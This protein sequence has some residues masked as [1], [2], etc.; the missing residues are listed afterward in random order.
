MFGAVTFA[1]PLQG[2]DMQLWVLIILHIDAKKRVKSR[3][4]LARAAAH[5]GV[6][7]RTVHPKSFRRYFTIAGVFFF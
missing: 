5:D 4:A 7:R 3:G 1:R 6:F 2:G